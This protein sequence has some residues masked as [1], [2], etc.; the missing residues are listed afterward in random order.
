[1]SIFVDEY[2]LFIFT[3]IYFFVITMLIGIF[4]K[5]SYMRKRVSNLT[6]EQINNGFVIKKQSN[7]FNRLYNNNLEAIQLSLDQAEI[8]MSLS[9]YLIF[10]CS[11]F[12]SIGIIIFISTH[13]FL[14]VLGWYF[15]FTSFLKNILS[16][17]KKKRI[18]KCSAQLPTVVRLIAGMITTG[19]SPLKALSDITIELEEPM[20]TEFEYI[21][22][23]LNLGLTFNEVFNNFYKKVPTPDIQLFVN[24]MI[25]QRETG[26]NLGNI[27]NK[28]ELILIEGDRIKKEQKA[29]VAQGKLSAIVLTFLPYIVAIL[30]W[31]FN[32]GFLAPLFTATG[33]YILLYGIV[34]SII[35]WFMIMKIV[36]VDY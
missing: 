32:P 19:V 5:K 9:K 31:L 22:K 34:S 23:S 7:F 3:F 33:L 8:K 2:K 27:L 18:K 28:M 11:V 6:S 21:V 35:G 13:N 1:M 30:I 15:L 29:L 20:K 10:R 16:S 36:E 25:I 26:A 17:I 12:V 4:N 14:F 24:A